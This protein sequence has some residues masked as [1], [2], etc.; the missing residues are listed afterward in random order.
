[1]KCRHI[2]LCVFSLLAID[3]RLFA[4]EKADMLVMK[5]GDHLTGEIKGLDAGVLYVS[6]GYIDGTTALN[7]SAVARLE[8]KQLF[9]VKTQDGSAYT[10]T[11]N[12]AESGAGRPVQIQVFEAAEHE[13]IIERSQIVRIV[14]T[15]ENFWQ[16]FNG[17]VSLG[18]IYSKGNESNQY[19]LGANILYVRERWNAG[20]SFDSN[21]SSSSGT[22]TVTR[23]SLGLTALHLLPKKNWYYG[24]IGGLLQSTE[25]AITLQSLLGGG[26]GRYLKNTDLAT[27]KLLGGVAW[28]DTTY[29]PTVTPVTGPNVTSALI[30]M[31]ARFFKFSKTNFEAT[32][33]I[34]PAFSDPGRIRMNTNASY[35]IKIISDLKWN[36]SFYGNWDNQPPP[37]VSGSDYGTSSGLMWAF[38]LK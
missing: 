1:M 9:V 15:S 2:L 10:G 19:S 8:S 22:N 16:R 30:Y 32:A 3:P 13:D 29:Q 36:I 5:N 20:A 38:G 4:R 37:G 12:T 26:V 28:Q 7:W 33:A 14:A 17:D 25:Q 35:S 11:L 6:F 34:L 27:I 21:L 31:D 24:G 18:T 23:N